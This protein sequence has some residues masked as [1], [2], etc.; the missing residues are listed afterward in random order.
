MILNKWW[1]SVRSLV[2]ILLTLGFLTLNGIFAHL[3]FEPP[4]IVKDKIVII[5]TLMTA[6]NTIYILTLNYYFKEKDRS[7]GVGTEENI[8][9]LKKE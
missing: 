5:S 1:Y 8:N 9:L 3:V 6:Y 7:N 2:T 4:E